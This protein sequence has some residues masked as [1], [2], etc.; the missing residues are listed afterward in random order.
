MGRKAKNRFFVYLAV[1]PYVRNFMLNNYGL[2]DAEFPDAVSFRQD[3]SLYNRFRSALVKPSVKYNS[4]YRDLKRYSATIQIEISR[5]D[6]YRYGWALNETETVAFCSLLE[7][8]VK[9]MLC[10]YID[11]HT[12]IGASIATAIRN[13][14][15]IFCF[16]EDV[17]P[18]D[19]IRR[20][21]NRN[22]TKCEVLGIEN[23]HKT[24]DKIIVVNLSRNGTISPCV[25]TAYEEY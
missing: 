3:H 4:R 9:A 5:D 21:Y 1:K 2:N 16:P 23:F 12:Q 20:E 13:F 6:F 10:T 22:R 24:I 25:K 17:W 8:R 15:K 18:Y 11:V 14:Q 19:S 7:S